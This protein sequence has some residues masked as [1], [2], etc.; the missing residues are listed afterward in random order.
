MPHL[1]SARPYNVIVGHLLGV[2]AGFA[3]LFFTHAWSTPAVPT[4]DVTLRRVFAAGLAAMLTVLF[5]MLANARQP[6]AISTALLIALG[7]MQTP[8]D[9][10]AIMAAVL[11]MAL[12][13]EPL[14]R[15][16]KRTL[17]QLEQT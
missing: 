15:W 13:G 6:A 9:A 14:R 17:P 7:I 3:A 2:A 11:L 4:S 8:T 5:T 12:L 1:H 10:A 16:R